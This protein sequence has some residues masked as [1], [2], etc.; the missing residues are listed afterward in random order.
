MWFEFVRTSFIALALLYTPGFLFFRGLGLAR[1]LALCAAPLLMV[2]VCSTLPLAYYEF[3][4]PCNALTILCPALVAAL[5]LW[6]VRHL[7]ARSR[8]HNPKPVI[9]LSDLEP[10]ALPHVRPLSFDAVALLVVFLLGTIV[11]ALVFLHSLPSADAFNPRYDNQTHVNLAR[12]YLESGKWSSIHSSTFLASPDY[13]S[14]TASLN[15][16]YP[17]AWTC[18]VVLTSLVSQSDLMIATNAIVALSAAAVF[19]LG[20]YAFL[21]IMLPK[22][23]RAVA[24]GVIAIVGFSHWPWLYVVTG[25]LFPNQLGIGLQFCALSV[26]LAAIETGGIRQCMASFLTFCVISFCA[27]ALSHPSTIFSLYVFMAF[28]GIHKLVRWPF[29]RTR[30]RVQLAL[31]LMGYAAIVVAFWAFCLELP[32]LRSTVEYTEVIRD[33]VRDALFSLFTMG[34]S[35]IS[36]QIGMSVASVIGCAIAL[37]RKELR[38]LLGPIAYFAL[39]YVATRIDWWFVKHWLTS[40]WYSDWRRMCVN[41]TLYLMPLTALGLD[42]L[43]PAWPE[44]NL[45]TFRRHR[46]A[47]CSNDP[48][49]RGGAHGCF[50][51]RFADSTFLSGRVLP[52]GPDAADS[53]SSHA[54]VPAALPIRRVFSSLRVVAFCA[55]LLTTFLPSLDLPSGAHLESSLAT[56]SQGIRERYAEQIFGTEEVAFVRKVIETIPPDTLV[57]N[58]PADGSMWAYGI[59]D[60]NA[61]YRSILTVGLTDDANVI[62]ER[63]QDYAS[64]AEVRDA[65]QHTGASYVLQLDKGIPY[66]EGAWLWQF[67]E[68]MRKDWRGIDAIDER[69]PGFSLV[70]AEGSD[71]RLYRIEAL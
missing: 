48:R 47:P 28:Y 33:D 4:I 71:M 26:I 29:M 66:H 64:D 13:A 51:W 12:A 10:V 67:T 55:I 59:C 70:L 31:L 25:P 65:V 62:R 6:G 1:N 27:L 8:H 5:G 2:C 52:G 40:L 11:C 16:F 30:P 39:G 53:A 24:L 3:G 38:W 57:I 50:P 61:Y 69:T 34:F 17:G 21:R 7:R 68:G 20:M 19:P 42:A 63:L 41:M 37:S 46:Q 43:L 14:S 45:K 23:R 32:M 9:A 49:S 54:P 60:L 18:I 56:V 22:R 15:V 44:R 36:P 35:F 58:Y